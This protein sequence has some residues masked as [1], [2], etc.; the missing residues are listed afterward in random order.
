MQTEILYSPAYSVARVIL[1]PGE[2]I[3]AESGAMMSMSPTIEME[4][5]M[6][7]GL[8]KA[9]GRLLGGESVFQTNFI[10]KH[11][12]G[13]IML[14]PSGPGDILLTQPNTGLMVTSGC[15]L[16]GDLNL[17]IETQANLRGFF[18]GEG[19]FMMRVFGPG[20]LLLSSFGAIHALQLQPGQPYVVDTGHLVAFTQGMGFEVRRAA[21][22]L[23]G[24]F[25]SGEGVVVVLTGPGLV[26]TQ[27]RTVA[28]FAGL[29]RPFIPSGG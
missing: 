15:Y 26:Y 28:N 9:F 18:A 4:S 13:E 10:A 6:Q 19:L 1:A 16:A 5:K 11:G 3:R 14:A 21:R 24:S 25:T 7:G 20:D 8:G 12:P 2:G 22:S 17:Q 27:T 23:L 29:I